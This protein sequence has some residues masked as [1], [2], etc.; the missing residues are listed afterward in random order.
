MQWSCSSVWQA[1]NPHAPLADAMPDC[2]WERVAG[3]SIANKWAMGALRSEIR[4]IWAGW[5]IF[6][7]TGQ[8]GSNP[9]DF[10][11][12]CR[13]TGCLIDSAVERV[14]LFPGDPG[15]T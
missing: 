13:K 15:T 8:P 14:G 2:I 12:Q 1:T 9:S 3:C 4:V 6:H 7:A 10:P 11:P 5:S